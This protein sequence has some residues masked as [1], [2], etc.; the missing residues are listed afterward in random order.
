MKYRF[1][2]WYKKAWPIVLICKVL[3]LSVSAYYAW[4]KRPYSLRKREN[5]TLIPIVQAI[6]V[7]MRQSFGTRRMATELRK[8][9]IDCGRCRARILMRLA[10]CVYALKSAL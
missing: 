4:C 3:K 5:E 6:H 7:K 2:E 9:G 1:V 10:N 8:Q